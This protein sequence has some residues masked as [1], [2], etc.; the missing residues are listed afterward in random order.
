MKI[1]ANK[2]GCVVL[3][4][5]SDGDVIEIILVNIIGEDVIYDPN[6]QHALRLLK[7]YLPLLL[8]DKAKLLEQNGVQQSH[9]KRLAK[10]EGPAP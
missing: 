6:P 1:V 4:T 5:F 2:Q 7:Q 10:K 3:C 9:I 8:P